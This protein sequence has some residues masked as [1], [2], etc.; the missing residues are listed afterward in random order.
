MQHGFGRDSAPQQSWRDSADRKR[1]FWHVSNS[2]LQAPSLYFPSKTFAA[3]GSAQCQIS[4]LPSMLLTGQRVGCVVAVTWREGIQKQPSGEYVSSE[5]EHPVRR[6]SQV[7]GHAYAG[8]TSGVEALHR[9]SFR[10][11]RGSLHENSQM[12][13]HAAGTGSTVIVG[14]GRQHAAHLVRSYL[15]RTV[16]DTTWK[17][18]F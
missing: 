16:T 9:E 11:G 2:L 18:G 6:R 14:N 10:N 8:R 4:G 5:P 15:A 3:Q 1:F 13:G 7:R 12:R 17:P